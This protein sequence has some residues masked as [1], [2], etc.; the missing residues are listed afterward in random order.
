MARDY[1]SEFF[2]GFLS[3][4]KRPARSTPSPRRQAL[5][6]RLTALGGR[7]QRKGNGWEVIGSNQVAWVNNLAGVEDT[8]S[9]FEREAGQYRNG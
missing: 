3:P 8:I 9:D 1:L 2:G 4:T 5:I 7:M 6:D